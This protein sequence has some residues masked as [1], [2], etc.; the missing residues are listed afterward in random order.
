MTLTA[1][2]TPAGRMGRPDKG[3]SAPFGYSPGYRGGKYLHHGQD[4]YWLNADPAGSRKVYAAGAGRVVKVAYD[5]T[6]GLCITIDHGAGLSSRSC[7][8][9]KGSARVKVGDYVTTSTLLGPMG[10]AGSA[11]GGQYH[12][13]FEAW[14]GGVRVDP[15]PY[16]TT[17]GS[18]VA[19][20]GSQ[21]TQ[22]SEN[23]MRAIREPS[24]GI[25]LVGETTYQGLTLAQWLVESKVWGGYTQL[26]LAEYNQ[27]IADSQV[28]RA[29]LL[30]GISGSGAATVDV[31][32]I[33]A[34][35]S[36]N[37]EADL[38]RLSGDIAAINT[39]MGAPTAD[40][41]ANAVWVSAADRLKS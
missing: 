27:A 13:H 12:L 34:K 5:S 40:E 18:S 14:L 36:A 2:P 21:I 39:A 38:V 25:T 23:E 41:I 8:M 3:L 24:G 26:A 10:N 17:V 35:V 4:Y 20:S 15:E 1:R 37:I 7:H 6:M 16:F 22:G 29:Y 32:A 9:P 19:G 33:I 30:A 31:D 28:R 11:A